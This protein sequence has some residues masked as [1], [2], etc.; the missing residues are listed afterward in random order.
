MDCS[1]LGNML[2]LDIQKGKEATKTENFQQQI[3]GTA[4]FMKRLM[5]ATKGCVQLT[6]ND[7]YFYDSWFSGLET[8]KEA[9]AEGVDYCRTVKTIHKVFF[10][11]TLEKLIK[12]W[13]GGSYLVLKSTS[14]VPSDI[15]LMTIGYKYN[16][17]KVL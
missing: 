4:A 3:R 6:S 9:M 16:Y 15:P 1:R 11:E 17:R 10:L 14:R 8:A 5:M 7:T 13:P 2:Y 12:Y